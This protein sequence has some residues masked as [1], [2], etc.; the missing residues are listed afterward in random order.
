MKLRNSKIICIISG[1]LL[2]ILGLNLIYIT[3]NKTK[4]IKILN[5]NI[6]KKLS[7][8]DFQNSYFTL[9]KR[10]LETTFYNNFSDAVKNAKYKVTSFKGNLTHYGPDCEGC[11][12]R[13]ACR[14]VDVRNGNIYYNDKDYGKVRIVAADRELPC[15]SIIKIN[16]D[17]YDKDGMYAIV[18][19]RGGAVNGGH[20]DLLKRYERE[21][22]PARTTR[23]VIF[24]I[25]RIG[26]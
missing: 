16:I 19:D 9:E 6:D 23:N 18:L 15:G 24:D 3:P 7:V 8:N 26:Y 13:T 11:G 10:T 5:P 2:L 1:F 22:S 12:G 20:I 14:R 21:P 4:T 25:L 17:A